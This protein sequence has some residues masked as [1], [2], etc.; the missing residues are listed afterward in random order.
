MAM[1]IANFLSYRALYTIEFIGITVERLEKSQ[2]RNLK[3]S[4]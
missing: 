2:M 3:H 4:E 1:I